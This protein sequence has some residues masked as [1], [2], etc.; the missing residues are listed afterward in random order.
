LAERVYLP[1]LWLLQAAIARAQG[2]AAA[3]AAPVRHAIEEARAR[4]AP[5]LELLALADL[6]EHHEETAAE[7]RALATLVDRLPEASDTVPV[8]RARSILQAVKP[9]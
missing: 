2:R 5:W 3:G 7:R 6:C 8:R 9:A 1:Q 4:E